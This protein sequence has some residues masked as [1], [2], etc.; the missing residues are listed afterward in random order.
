MMLLLMITHIDCLRVVVIVVFRGLIDRL[1]DNRIKELKLHN[2]TVACIARFKIH[3]RK[4][5]GWDC[6]LLHIIDVFVRLL[7]QKGLQKEL[8]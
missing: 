5:V 6:C 2:A 7:V 8:I 3:V 4:A 1:F